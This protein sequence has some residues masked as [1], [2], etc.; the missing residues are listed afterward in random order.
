M[1]FFLKT[2]FP[3]NLKSNQQAWQ[4]NPAESC[5]GIEG[6]DMGKLTEYLLDKHGIVASHI[7][8]PDGLVDGIRIVVNISLSV[9][10]IDYFAEVVEDVFKKGKIAGKIDT[11]AARV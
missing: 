11:A 3:L 9:K 6:I 8:H 7:T 5:F 2:K 4:L 10:E 1:P